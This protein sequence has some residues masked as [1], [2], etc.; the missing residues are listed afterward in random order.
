MQ[1][2]DGLPGEAQNL[3][4]A[5][6][7]KGSSESLDEHDPFCIGSEVFCTFLP[8]NNLFRLCLRLSRQPEIS[9]GGFDGVE[10]RSLA[11]HFPAEITEQFRSM[12]E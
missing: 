2:P 10:Q 3:A 1:P 8:E 4:R 11:G 5:G 9:M 12:L 6:P 7:A